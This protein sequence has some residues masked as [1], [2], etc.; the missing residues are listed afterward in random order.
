MVALQRLFDAPVQRGG[1]T[2]VQGGEYFGS[3]VHRAVLA[4]GDGDATRNRLA[5][6]IQER[7]PLSGSVGPTQLSRIP[8]ILLKGT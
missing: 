5:I 2:E 3:V 8:Q 1:V 7:V 4:L 6:V